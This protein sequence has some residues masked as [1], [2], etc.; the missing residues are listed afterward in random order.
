MNERLMNAIEGLTNLM[1]LIEH[2]PNVSSNV[3]FYAE[4]AKLTL[5]DLRSEVMLLPVHRH[6]SD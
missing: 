3:L 4:Q 5:D 1:Y 6:V 2:E